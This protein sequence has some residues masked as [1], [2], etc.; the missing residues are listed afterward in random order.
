MAPPLTIFVEK[1]LSIDEHFAKL[2]AVSTA[3][4]YDLQ[5][6]EPEQQA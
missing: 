1:R 4:L 5:G 2:T 6:I 3:I